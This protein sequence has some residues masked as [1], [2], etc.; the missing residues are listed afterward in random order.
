[1]TVTPENT[2]FVFSRWEGHPSFVVELDGTPID[3]YW[4]DETKTWRRIHPAEI[5][6]NAALRSRQGLE[7][8]FG[9]LPPLPP[10]AFR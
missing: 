6:V 4:L 7:E 9:K 2:E 8:E 3:A 5:F 10:A 1:M